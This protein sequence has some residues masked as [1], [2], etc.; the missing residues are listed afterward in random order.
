MVLFLVSVAFI[1]I[2]MGLI[3][4]LSHRLIVAMLMPI[5]GNNYIASQFATFVILK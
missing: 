4:E 1:R 3:Y 2:A 5:V